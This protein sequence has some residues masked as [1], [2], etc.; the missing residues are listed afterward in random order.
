MLFATL[1]SQ[2]S[3]SDAVL[4]FQVREEALRYLG[5]L[6]TE[7]E[8]E[9]LQAAKALQSASAATASDI[10]PTLPV[11][12]VEPLLRLL[13]RTLWEL[14]NRNLPLTRHFFCLLLRLGKAGVSSLAFLLLE[15]SL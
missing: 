6:F 1:L 11:D 9:R 13:P 2:H 8:E 15:S 7:E 10:T 14:R 12:V 4:T 5:E 3:P